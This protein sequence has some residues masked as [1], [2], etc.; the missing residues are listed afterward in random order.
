MTDLCV[1]GSLY[2]LTKYIF[3]NN[4]YLGSWEKCFELGLGL[5][6]K[7]CPYEN[8]NKEQ[9]CSEGSAKE[10]IAFLKNIMKECPDHSMDVEVAYYGERLNLINVCSKD[11]V[12][13]KECHN[14]P[15]VYESEPLKRFPFMKPIHWDS[16]LCNSSCSNEYDE[17][18]R[19]FGNSTACTTF[20]DESI[21][22]LFRSGNSTCTETTEILTPI[23]DF[24][25][26][27]GGF[28][29]SFVVYSIILSII[30]GILTAYKIKKNKKK[31]K[32]KNDQQDNNHNNNNTNNERNTYFY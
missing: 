3:S 20:E 25:Y 32:N 24:K 26:Y 22:K 15:K 2:A 14:I 12:T 1:N 31:N 29:L 19:E 5:D 21:C 9:Y 23:K 17:L 8:L 6:G 10:F 13:G 28:L 30:F 7:D 11:N 18:Y 16:N 27:I 4:L